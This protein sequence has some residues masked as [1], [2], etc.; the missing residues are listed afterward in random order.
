M[1]VGMRL[2]NQG[3]QGKANAQPD[4]AGSQ[5]VLDLPDFAQ[6]GSD[7]FN[8]RGASCGE[9]YKDT[10]DNLCT[11][12]PLTRLVSCHS[13]LGWSVETHI[14]LRVCFLFTTLLFGFNFLHCD[15]VY[16]STFVTND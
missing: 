16:A 8:G 2:A 15:D 13:C 9:Q 7:A 14:H 6:H 12:H 11:R 5:H 4:V 10:E 3:H 1:H